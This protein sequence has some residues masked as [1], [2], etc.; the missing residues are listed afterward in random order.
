[1]RIAS[2]RNRELPHLF[3]ELLEQLGVRRSGGAHNLDRLFE[4]IDARGHCI[5]FTILLFDVLRP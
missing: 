3:H 2:L 1:M 5:E 4:A